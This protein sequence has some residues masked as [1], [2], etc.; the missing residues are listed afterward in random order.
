LA[1]ICQIQVT[2]DAPE[3]VIGWDALVEAE[4]IEQPRRRLLKPNHRRSSCRISR[5]QGITP[6]SDGND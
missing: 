5:T 6:P 4:I 2:V 1:E 3:H